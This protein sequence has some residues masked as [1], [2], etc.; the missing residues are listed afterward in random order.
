MR[1]ARARTSGWSSRRARAAVPR[2]DEAPQGSGEG[3]QTAG[4]LREAAKNRRILGIAIVAAIGGFLFGYDTGVIGGALL[5]IQKDL[6]LDKGQ[7]Q[8][9]V[10]VDPDRR[11]RRRDRR[12]LARRPLQ[13]PAHEDPGG[14]RL[15]DRR[16][17][18]R[19]R[20]ELLAARRGA[21]LARPRRRHR[22]VRL[23]DVHRRARP[24]A[25]PRR[26]RQL[27]PADGHA[28]DPARVH[29]RLGVRGPL[30]QLALDVR[31]S[32][33]SR[34]P[35]SRSGCSSC[36]T[37]RAGSSSRGARTRRRTCSPR[38]RGPEDDIDGE[39]AEIKDV[40]KNEASLGDLM[41]KAVRPMLIVG[42]GLAIFQQIV[43]INTVIYYAPTILKFAGQQNTGA[44]TQSLL[45]RRDERRLHDRRD[46]AARQ[47]RPPLLPARRARAAASSP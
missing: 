21:L 26:R 27:Q 10:S 33:R 24:A 9:A 13:P 20:P 11:D 28:R 30:E 15:R 29:L 44:L 8:L 37:R 7:Q 6:N 39:I 17:R 46:P 25:H 19:A 4:L 45:H 41:K 43:G 3:K 34:A 18:L 38:L 1:R 22:V 42:I 14:L 5:F 32:P 40:T 31:P 47:A 16:V 35:R 23:A 36:R 12:R 2:P